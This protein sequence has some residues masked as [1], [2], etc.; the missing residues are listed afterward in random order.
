SGLDWTSAYDMTGLQLKRRL[1]GDVADTVEA[2]L[3]DVA[4]LHNVDPSTWA[5]DAM[6]IVRDTGAAAL[7][8]GSSEFSLQAGYLRLDRG[9][10]AAYY[11]DTPLASGA[12]RYGLDDD[13][14]LEGYSA[15][16]DDMRNTGLGV[17]QDFGLYGRFGLSAMRSRSGD[18]QG[19]QWMATYSGNIGK[20]RYFAG[21]QHR[22]P[23]F[24]DLQ[25]TFRQ[26]AGRS[27]RVPFRHLHTAGLSMPTT[28]HGQLRMN[29][30]RMASPGAA[31]A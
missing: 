27:T 7:A 28:H 23:D 15:A 30:V 21:T 25:R 6:P 24:F 31:P 8:A 29:F 2:V 13:L 22:T 11:G 1:G 17:V 5:W 12:I 19:H 14:T 4:Q 26:R 16:T 9:S 3:P 20:I 10:P 18:A